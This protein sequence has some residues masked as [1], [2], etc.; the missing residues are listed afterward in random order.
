MNDL[1]VKKNAAFEIRTRIVGTDGN[2]ACDEPWL[3]MRP[4]D[5]TGEFVEISDVGITPLDHGWVLFQVPVNKV[6]VPSIIQ[7]CNSTP[8]FCEGWDVEVYL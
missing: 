6:A 1:R 7:T 8:A 5:G 2:G 3:E 4:S